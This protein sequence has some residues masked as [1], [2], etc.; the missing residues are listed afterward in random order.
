MISCFSLYLDMPLLD[1]L[2]QELGLQASSLAKKGLTRAQLRKAGDA[3]RGV[4]AS[5][6][7]LGGRQAGTLIASCCLFG[8]EPIGKK[9]AHTHPQ[10]HSHTHTPTTTLSQAHTNTHTATHPHTHPITAAQVYVQGKD[11]VAFRMAKTIYGMSDTDATTT[12]FKNQQGQ[13]VGQGALT[14]FDLNWIFGI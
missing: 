1:Y 3:L 13:E 2:A 9:C 6:V 8:Y 12:T 14:H 10:P 5:Y 11:K 4:K 7:M